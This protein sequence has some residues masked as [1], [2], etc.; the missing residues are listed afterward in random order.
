MRD[1]FLLFIILAFV[2]SLYLEAK[3]KLP[4]V[5]SDRMVLQREQPIKIWGT[6][7]P[8]ESIHLQFRKKEY[9]IVA[10]L[11]GTWQL[12]LPAG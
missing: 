9:E 8:E 3:V 2:F 6:A 11:D 1:K 7:A 5:L 4:A 12:H 10:S